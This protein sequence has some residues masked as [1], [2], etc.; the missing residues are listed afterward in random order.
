[1]LQKAIPSR[2]VKLPL[3]ATAPTP[4]TDQPPRECVKLGDAARYLDCSQGTLENWIGAKKFTKADGL[5]RV[6]GLTRIHM[7]TL[8]A[9]F[10]SGTLMT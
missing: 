10:A 5:R 3:A 1:M 6:G 7:P 4:T 8:R 9:R 2:V